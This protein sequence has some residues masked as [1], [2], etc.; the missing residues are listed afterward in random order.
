MKKFIGICLV[1]LTFS[2]VSFEAS[3]QKEYKFVGR[4]A[5][6]LT[7]DTLINVTPKATMTV[8]T[9]SATHAVKLNAITTYSVPG[10]IVVFKIKATSANRAITFNDA[11]DAPTET[12]NSGKT[13]TYT[14]VYMG[15]AYV[16]TAS[17]AVD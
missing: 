3:A 1:L 2:L 5:A 11:I 8:Y 13:K 14:L 16:L 10:D 7:S 6:T 17:A 9:L 12:I 4:Q 15:A